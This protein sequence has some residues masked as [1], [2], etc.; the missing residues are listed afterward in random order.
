MKRLKTTQKR[1]FSRYTAV[2]GQH[3]STLNVIKRLYS[4]LS[5]ANEDALLDIARE[6]YLAANPEAKKVP[7]RKWLLAFLLGYNP[8]TK[9]VYEHEVDRKRARLTEAIIAVGV[10]QQEFITAFNLFWKQTAQYGIDVTDASTLKAYK[11]MGVKKVR[12][13]TEEDNRVCKTCKDRN[14]KIYPISKLPSKPHYNCRCWFEAVKD[15]E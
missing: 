5:K 14:N 11:D 6:A 3:D 7:D 1:L 15:G 4:D 9:Y 2:I 12:W 13:K 10:K 8:V